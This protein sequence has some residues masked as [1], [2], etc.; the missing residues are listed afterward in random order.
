MATRQDDLFGLG[1]QP[2]STW[3]KDQPEPTQAAIELLTPGSDAH[4]RVLTYLL[5]RLEMSERKMSDFYPR[6]RVSEKKLQAYVNLTDHEKVLKELTDKK[7]RPP[8]AVS[9]VVPYSYA[10]HQTF[11][12]YMIHTFCGR[13]PIFQIGTNKPEQIQN[14]RNMEQLLQYNAD[15]NR[16]IKWLYQF[17]QD[18]FGYGLGVIR[19]RWE[20]QK[21]FRTSRGAVPTGTFP[22]A[23]AAGPVARRELRTVYAGNVIEAQDP[24]MFFPDPRVPLTEVS[25]R[26]EFVF[27]RAFEGRHMLLRWEQQM[28]GRVRWV[29]AA[30][31]K[32]PANKFSADTEGSAR[33]LVSMGEAHP[34]QDGKE[35]GGV[36]NFVQVD[37]GTVE[38][39]PAELGLGE[40]RIPEKWLFTIV[41]KSQIIQAESF[42]AD[43]DMHPV[44]CT[45]PYTLGYGFGNPGL[46]DYMGPLQDT[47]SWLVDSHIYNVRAV[48]NNMLV[49]DP[50][51]VEM[52]DLQNPEP[53]KLI[54]LKRAFYGSD[55]REALYQ[56][57]LA[58]VT[59]GHL[60]D[61]DAFATFSQFISGASS[62]LMGQQDTGGRKTATE[63]RTAGENSAS[64]L[65]ALARLI[66]AQGMI[67]LAEQQVLNLQ[68]Y[69]DEE[70]TVQVLGQDGAN[71]LRTLRPTDLTGDFYF[72]VH[73]GTLP[74]DRVAMLDVWKEIFLAVAQQPGLQQRFDLTKIFEYTAELGGAKNIEQFKVQM[75]PD[76]QAL[77]GAASGQLLPVGAA[78][79]AAASNGSGGQVR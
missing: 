7:G 79:A 16:L 39:I 22:G 45:E 61:A 9:I 46:T 23:A 30:S 55:V 6:W 60:R 27:W 35:H 77:A 38:I 10:I 33:D 74:L 14:A 64:R 2:Q 57:N 68:Q 8:Q 59:T 52:Q 19:T 69:M 37:Q 21:A 29:N 62:N 18:G 72:P 65:A 71:M 28:Q 49:V 66:S 4:S 44:S 32:L 48:L 15:R 53:G 50:S 63:V 67:D 17:F 36:Q 1:T 41:N 25:R 42:G 11:V 5:Q 73:D 13:K 75:V 47:I 70:F 78:T 40:S 3:P 54:R 51:R 20:V 58:D 24:F 43:H 31:S 34:G 12:T 56:L 76:Q 26:G